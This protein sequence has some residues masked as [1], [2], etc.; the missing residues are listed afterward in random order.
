MFVAFVDL[1]MW[2]TS[3]TL[4]RSGTGR[5]RS[6]AGVSGV[7]A[8]KKKTQQPEMSGRAQ[9]AHERG[10]KLV[11]KRLNNTFLAEYS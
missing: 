2:G 4:V 10:H 7:P 3:S 1:M 8:D 6:S 9:S 5:R 11:L